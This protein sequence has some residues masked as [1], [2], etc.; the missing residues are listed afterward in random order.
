MCRSSSSTYQ[1][2][3]MDAFCEDSLDLNPAT[4]EHDIA[5]GF[6]SVKP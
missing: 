1:D 6:D 5:L 2:A 4:L 3:A